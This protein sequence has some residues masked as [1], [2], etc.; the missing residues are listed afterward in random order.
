VVLCYDFIV[1]TGCID[2]KYKNNGGKLFF[3]NDENIDGLSP[4]E[5]FEELKKITELSTK[6]YR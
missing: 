6:N 5:S 4:L 2:M 3:Y 1:F